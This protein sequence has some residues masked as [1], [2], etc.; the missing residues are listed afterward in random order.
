MENSLSLQAVLDAQ[1]AAWE[2]TASGSIQK[3]Y[4]EGITAVHQSGVLQH[5]KNLGDT[6]PGFSL[7]NATGKTVTLSEYLDKG[8]VILTWYRGGWCPYCNLTLQ[9]LRQELPRFKAAGAN[10][11]VLTPELPDRSLST[12]E[13]HELQFE[14]LSDI[15]NTVAGAYGIVFSLTSEV[16]E[17]Y[18]NAFDLHAYNGNETNELPL[19]AT[20]VIDRE[21]VIRYAFL[22]AEYR[23]RAEPAVILDA[24]QKL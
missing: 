18:Q 6:A 24:L 5:A 11:L 1:R 7:T 23:N 16:A 14:V 3:I 12:K 21:S 22:D 20:Y 8:P 13:K 19:A 15:D 17:S 9:R 4:D 2:K 10:V